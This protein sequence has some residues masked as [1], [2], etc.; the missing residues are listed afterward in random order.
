MCQALLAFFSTLHT[1]TYPVDGR[2][3]GDPAGAGDVAVVE[4][5]PARRAQLKH[6]AA[7]VRDPEIVHHDDLSLWLLIHPINQINTYLP[8]DPLPDEDLLVLD[9]VALHAP[10][11][12]AGGA[13]RQELLVLGVG[14]GGPRQR[15]L[16]GFLFN[17]MNKTS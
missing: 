8:G 15:G 17:L 2:D 1:P 16:V 12:A 13:V 9:G 11:A 14:R 10:L 3:E 5:H 6:L 7:L 4:P